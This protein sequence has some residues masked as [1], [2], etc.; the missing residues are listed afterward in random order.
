MKLRINY[1]DNLRTIMIFLLIP[2]H[3]AMAYNIWSEPNYI[4]L[5][6]IRRLLQL[7]C[8]CHHGLLVKAAGTGR[9]CEEVAV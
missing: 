3:L 8:L 9:E 7:W 6:K 2:Y 5:K 4:F 1:I